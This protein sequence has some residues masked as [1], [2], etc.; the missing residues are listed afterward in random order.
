MGDGGEP[1][2][3]ARREQETD[4]RNVRDEASAP[5]AA[6]RSREGEQQEPRVSSETTNTKKFQKGR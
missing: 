1:R 2:S 3:N 5:A 4:R 6:P